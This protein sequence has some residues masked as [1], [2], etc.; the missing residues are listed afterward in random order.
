VLA[1]LAGSG[2]ARVRDYADVKLAHQYVDSAAM[3]LV[4]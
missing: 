3:L 2:H 4:V 1:A